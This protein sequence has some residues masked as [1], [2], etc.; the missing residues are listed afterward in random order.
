MRRRT[1]TIRDI[2]MT[3][4]TDR[5]IPELFG[6]ALSQLAKLIGN[7]FDLARAELSQKAGQFS[8]GVAMITAGAVIM[9]PAVVML[10]FAAAAAL[11]HAGLSDPLSYLVTGIAA[12]VVAG[13]LVRIGFRRMSRDALRPQMTLDQIK[14]DQ[15]AA[16]EMVR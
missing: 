16:K 3:S 4:Q 8:R 7:E 13:A 12:A 6:D 15:A 5:S 2:V 1:L 9:A 10:L 14:Q 11:M